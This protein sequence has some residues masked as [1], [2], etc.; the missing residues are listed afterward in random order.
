[1]RALAWILLIV[2]ICVGLLIAYTL[3]AAELKVE[4]AEVRVV[5][6]GGMVT[7]FQSLHRAVQER[8][9]LGKQFEE[10]PADDPGAYDFHL[11]TVRLRNNG[12][13]PA[14]WVRL[15]VR[16][17]PGAVLQSD[18]ESAGEIPAMSAG[19]IQLVVLARRGASAARQLSLTYFIWSRT[20][21]IPVDVP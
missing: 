2:T 8:A 17:E 9:L 4:L 5:P 12:L 18:S 6:A 14:D 13:V 1:M 15:D 16:P 3:Y 10:G 11:Y 19:E 21:N 7:E 20:Y